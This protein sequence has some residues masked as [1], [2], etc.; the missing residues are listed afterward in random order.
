MKDRKMI[1]RNILNT[2]LLLLIVV[3]AVSLSCETYTPAPLQQNQSE[4]PASPS[5][6]IAKMGERSVVLSWHLSSATTTPVK[7]FRIYRNESADNGIFARLGQTDTTRYVDSTV[8]S[9]RQYFYQI[10]AVNE[11]GFEGEHSSTVAVTPSVYSIILQNGAPTVNQQNVNLSVTGPEDTKFMM[12]SNDS[13]F[14]NAHWEPFATAREWKLLPGDG[15]KQVFAKFRSINDVETASLVSASIILDTIATIEFIGD[16]SN[17]RT[18]QSGDTLHIR[19]KSGEING[20]ASASIVDPSFDLPG[21]GEND[22][23]LYDDGSHGDAVADDGIYETDYFIGH[24]FEVE[25]AFLFGYFTDAVGNVADRAAAETQL[26]VNQAPR[27]VVLQEPT[28]AETDAPSLVLRWSANTDIDFASYQVLRSKSY[29]VSLSSSLVQEIKDVKTT[30]FID[31]NLEP[32]TQYYYRIYVFD[33]SGNSTA[34]NIV[35]GATADNVAPKP[36]VLSQPSADSVGL[37]LTWSPSSENDFANYRLY[38][39]TTSPVDTSFAPIHI[40]ND[41]NTTEYHDLSVSPN[42]DYYYQ[43]FV[44]DK[45]NLS[46]GSNE[47]QGRKNP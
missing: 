29:L 2:L 20:I 31:E 17:G 21:R 15:L 10:A 3:G 4:L 6:V 40:F 35:S 43:L 24:G 39:S 9:G 14:E 1:S 5:R 45:Y 19:L 7:S 41:K 22:I 34:S 37:L 47:V 18:L 8:T 33:A 28:N 42:I 30:S 16:D 44:Y 26:T 11:Q 13:L 25:N 12:F 36:V 32:A 27:S 46:A 38:R 23:R